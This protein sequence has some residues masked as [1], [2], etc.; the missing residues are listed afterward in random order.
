MIIKKLY[1]SRNSLK[2][3][4]VAVILPVV[5]LPL[6]IVLFLTSWITGTYI[7][8]FILEKLDYSNKQI[9]DRFD[10]L[11]DQMEDIMRRMIVNPDVQQTLVQSEISHREVN[12]I[13]NYIKLYN[14]GGIRYI[15][16]LDNRHNL[17]QTHER[18]AITVKKVLHSHIL[19]VLEG[20]YARQVWTFHT[21]DLSD[22]P[23]RYLFISRYIRH[24]DLNV[25]P[26]ILVLNIDPEVLRDVFDPRLMVR[27][28][29]Y[30]LLDQD[31][32]IVFHSTNPELIGEQPYA[33][34]PPQQK[35]RYIG[36]F[37]MRLFNAPQDFYSYHENY[38]TKWKIYSAI[39]YRVAL[40]ELRQLQ[41]TIYLVML[42]SSIG[43][44]SVAYIA[45]LRFTKPIRDLEHAMHS[46][47]EG[48]FNTRI[49]INRTDEIGE[50]G[51]SFNS[52]ADE[53]GSLI[54]TIQQDQEALTA[55]EL[56]SLAYQINPHFIYNVLDNVHML[57]RTT[58]EER[59]S[60]LII[61][62]TKLLRISLSKGHN[63]IPLADEFEHVRNYLN[64][65]K[66]RYGEMF[67][68]E[69]TLDPSIS[70]FQIVKLIL[71]PLAENCI[72][73]GFSDME[74]D[75]L[76]TIKGSKTEKGVEILV[77]DNG[78]GM[79]YVMCA[80]LNAL[81]YLSTEE[82]FEA[83]PKSQGGYGIGNVVARLNIYYNERYQ[84]SF[85]SGKKKGT[86]C[87]LI[88]SNQ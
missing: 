26:G 50:M 11:T 29:A 69:V 36:G 42:L 63:C 48:D 81:R 64:I 14:Y 75:G 56:E 61:S 88:I 52:M 54:N 16:F 10:R 33:I 39:P 79:P 17:I 87:R 82:I 85:V 21:D 5:I 3:R 60:S 66:I 67:N 23:G 76:I 45:A 80:K 18:S 32:R 86:Q 49:A 47:R 1:Q 12:A 13:S 38:R 84:I 7:K 74:S 31:D 58:G 15:L 70:N 34:L 4:M 77:W 25:N 44:V 27:G 41:S 8:T 62:L 40:S 35:R 59:I 83:F 20:T 46:F 55:A 53:I 37:P 65:Q 22:D 68:F 72:T 6:I 51:K 43:A 28:A 2:A 19:P 9:N 73:H 24:L 78:T 30:F 71:Q 57:A